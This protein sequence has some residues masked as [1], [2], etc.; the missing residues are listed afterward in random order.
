MTMRRGQRTLFLS[1]HNLSQLLTRSLYLEVL[2]VRGAAYLGEP[3]RR[4]QM[5]GQAT[6]YIAPGNCLKGLHKPKA[7]GLLLGLPAVDGLPATAGSVA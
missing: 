6:P 5:H 3:I 2:V 1:K 4:P 7:L